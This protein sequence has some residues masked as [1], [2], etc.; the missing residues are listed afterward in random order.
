MKCSTSYRPLFLIGSKISCRNFA[1][2]APFVR[3]ADH[4]WALGGLAMI[5][6]N[7]S[8]VKFAISAYSLSLQLAHNVD[9][10][11]TDTHA[12]A[13]DMH[14][15]LKCFFATQGNVIM[16]TIYSPASQCSIE[17]ENYWENFLERYTQAARHM[18]GILETG[19]SLR[20]FLFGILAPGYDAPNGQVE[21]VPVIGPRGEYDSELSS[22]VVDVMSR[23]FEAHHAMSQFLAMNVIA[24]LIV[25]FLDNPHPY[26]TLSYWLGG[27]VRTAVLP[28]I[29]LSFGYYELFHR[30]NAVDR[31]NLSV[32]EQMF[33]GSGQGVMPLGRRSQLVCTRDWRHLF[34]FIFFPIASLFYLTVPQFR[35]SIFHL[36]SDQLDYKVAPKP[37][38][39]KEEPIYVSSL[40][41]SGSSETLASYTQPD[42]AQSILSFTSRG[43]D[44]GF[45]DFDG[46]EPFSPEM[47]QVAK[48]NKT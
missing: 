16:H 43:A 4:I 38:I 40:S 35:D 28:F 27:W 10:W 44:S 47:W 20:R 11:D 19:Y 41:V 42:E 34:D 1:N 13:E 31:W 14:M 12:V 22:K 26:I 46:K 24:C 33:P 17:S 2:A 9:Y 39:T 8:H 18:W 30:W 3:I 45:F 37:Q 6:M 48:P 15:A 25:P 36:F 5:S 29:L 23:L 21:A 32:Q 7:P